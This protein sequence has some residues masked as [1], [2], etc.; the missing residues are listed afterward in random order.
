MVASVAVLITLV[1]LVVGV[2]QNT[3]ITRSAAYDRSMAGLNEWRLTIATDP[4]LASLFDT[5]FQKDPA[6]PG[7]ADARLGFMLN[8]LWGVYENAYYAHERRILGDAEWSRF[9]FQICVSYERDRYRWTGSRPIRPFLT[10][11]FAS[12]TESRCAN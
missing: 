9:E 4:E 11:D 6:S 2:R 12:Y 5:Y 1:F 3:E 7:P 8:A 10:E